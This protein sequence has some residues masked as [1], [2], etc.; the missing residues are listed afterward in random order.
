MAMPMSDKRGLSKR[1]LAQ[2]KDIEDLNSTM[3][4]SL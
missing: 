4:Q 2:I 1:V 3:N